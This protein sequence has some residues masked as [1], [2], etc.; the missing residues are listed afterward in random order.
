MCRTPRDAGPGERRQLGVGDRRGNGCSRPCL[1]YL[2][3]SRITYYVGISPAVLAG[4]ARALAATRAR[5]GIAYLWVER[6][7]HP[8][9]PL[10][11]VLGVHPAVVYQAARRGATQAREWDRLLVKL[12]KTT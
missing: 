6:L 12:C 10:A 4:G 5:A 8:G 3:T 2:A 1:S 7:G 9:R 11:P